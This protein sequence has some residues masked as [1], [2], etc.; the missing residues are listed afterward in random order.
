[1]LALSQARYIDKVLEWFS[2]QNSKKGLL[3]FRHGVLLFD[4]QRP[5]T[6]KEENMMRQVPYASVVGS[7]MYAMLCIR[8]NICYSVGMV[9]RYQSNP[10]PKHWQTVKHILKYLWR[11]SDYM[12]VYRCED[13]IPIGHTDSD[14]QLDLDF[15]KYTSICVFTLGG[16]AKSWRSVKQSCIVGSTMEDEYVAA[17][18]VAK[19]S[20]S[21][22]KFLSDLGVVRMEQVPI[23]FICDNSGAVAQSKDPRNHKKGKHIERKYHIIRDIVARGDVVVSKIDGANNLVDPFTKALPQRTFESHLEGVGVRLVHNRL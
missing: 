10:G 13:F 23:T 16:G 3:P 9:S 7:L 2:M 6:L 15:R 5:K 1:M 20:I 17:C 19:E 18:E 12:L 21:L 14:F 11:T 4:D 22:K 8:P